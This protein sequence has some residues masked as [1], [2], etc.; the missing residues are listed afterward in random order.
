MS[1]DKDEVEISRK[2]K[3]GWYKGLHH[4]IPSS[5]G[6]N[7]SWGNIYPR[8]RWGKKYKQK[9]DAYHI[10]FI[11]LKPKEVVE[12]I[13]KHCGEDGKISEEFFYTIFAVEER[14]RVTERKTS[15]GPGKRRKSWDI[16]F[17]AMNGFEAIEWIKREFIRKEWLTTTT[18][19]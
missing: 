18:P 6:G 1:K 19:P 13:A 3:T 16:V 17:G 2:R 4:I 11:N 5:R 15:R 10:L 7:E 12:R 9:H 8:E 14:G